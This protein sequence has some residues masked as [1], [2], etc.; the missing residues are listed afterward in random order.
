M[1]KYSQH[2][3]SRNTFN[4]FIKNTNQ[5]ILLKFTADWC[6]PCKQIEPTVHTEFERLSNNNFICLHVDIEEYFDVYVFLKSKKMVGGIPTILHYDP[7]NT[8][9]YAPNDVFVGANL[10]EL[11]KFFNKFN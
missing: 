6:E 4:D 10:I 11:T 2:F 9:C 5:H 1:E 3:Q 8:C 7:S